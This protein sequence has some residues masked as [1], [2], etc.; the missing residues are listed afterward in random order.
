MLVSILAL[1]FQVEAAEEASASEEASP[2]R[3]LT[4]DALPLASPARLLTDDAFPVGVVVSGHGAAPGVYVRFDESDIA[5]FKHDLSWILSWSGCAW[6]LQE[7][8]VYGDLTCG[9]D[10]LAV[11]AL[12]ASRGYNGTGLCDRADAELCAYRTFLALCPASCLENVGTPSPRNKS[13]VVICLQDDDAAVEEYLALMGERVGPC[14]SEQVLARCESDLVARALCKLT[15][16]HPDAFDG[17]ATGPATAIPVAAWEDEHGLL[18]RRLRRI[19]S[20]RAAA[21]AAAARTLQAVPELLYRTRFVLMPPSGDMG[22]VAAGCPTQECTQYDSCAGC[23]HDDLGALGLYGNGPTC[24]LDV[25]GTYYMGMKNICVSNNMYM[26]CY[27]SP[28]QI[29]A[30]SA[31]RRAKSAIESETICEAK[32]FARSPLRV[33][34][35]VCD[36]RVS[37]ETHSG[38]FCPWRNVDIS[39]SRLVPYRCEDGES[40]ALCIPRED[41]EKLCTELGADCV[42]IDF[43]RGEDRCFLNRAGSCPLDPVA[44]LTPSGFTPPELRVELSGPG[45]PGDRFPDGHVARQLKHDEA[46]TSTGHLLLRKSTPTTRHAPKFVTKS[47]YICVRLN[48]AL[49]GTASEDSLCSSNPKNV[50]EEAGLMFDAYK[51]DANEAVCLEREGC[52]ALCASL[53]TCVGFD[54]HKTLGICYLNT[55]DCKSSLYHSA[56]TLFDLVEKRPPGGCEISVSGAP[57][58]YGFGGAYEETVEGKTYTRGEDTLEYSA[59]SG[60]SLRRGP[61]V[62]YTTCSAP[63]TCATQG[64]LYFYCPGSDLVSVAGDEYE[65]CPLYNYC[66]LNAERGANE[67]AL[68]YNGSSSLNPLCDAKQ[69]AAYGTRAF[70]TPSRA[71]LIYRHPEDEFHDAAALLAKDLF[72]DTINSPHVRTVQLAGADAY[73]LRVVD[74]AAAEAELGWTLGPPAGT[75]KWVSDFLFLERYLDGSFLNGTATAGVP[76]P[77]VGGFLDSADADDSQIELWLPE[78]PEDLDLSFVKVVLLSRTGTTDSYSEPP[79]DLFPL[80]RTA[81]GWYRLTLA[82]SPFVQFDCALG[83]ALAL[84]EDECSLGTHDCD[85]HAVCT[86]TPFGHTCT[87]IDGWIGDGSLCL[88]NRWYGKDAPLSVV[89]ENEAEIHAGWHVKEIELFADAACTDPIETSLQWHEH[90][91]KYCRGNNVLPVLP[92]NSAISQS[93]VTNANCQG[94]P[95]DPNYEPVDSAASTHAL[96]P[97]SIATCRSWCLALP[98]CVGFDYHKTRDRCYI[99]YDSTSEPCKD[100]V[101]TGTLGDDPDYS[102]YSKE[103]LVSVE[104]SGAYEK[105]P[106]EL[107]ADGENRSEWWSAALHVKPRAASV[108]VGVRANR[109]VMSARVTQDA[110]H[111]G[112]A[113]H[114]AAAYRVHVSLAPTLGLWKVR[115]GTSPTARHVQ[116]LVDT[117][118]DRRYTVTKLVSGQPP[119]VDLTCG[120]AGRALPLSTKVLLKFDF[121]PTPCHCKELCLVWAAKGCASWTMYVERDSTSRDYSHI[122]SECYL[123]Q[124]AY[125]HK[126]TRKTPNWVSGGIDVLLFGFEPT[127]MSPGELKSLKIHAAGLSVKNPERQRLKIVPETSSCDAP[128]SPL[129]DG[130]RCSA[131]GVCTPG[132]ASFSTTHA[133]WPIRIAGGSAAGTYT[134]CYCQ[135]S[136]AL[137]EEWSAVP[138]VLTVRGGFSFSVQSKTEAADGQ[139]ATFS[140]LL[141]ASATPPGTVNVDWDPIIQYAIVQGQ[142]CSSGSVS[143]SGEQTA[144]PE[145]VPVLSDYVVTF[146]GVSLAASTGAYTVCARWKSTSDYL[147]AASGQDNR[148]LMVLSPPTLPVGLRGVSAWSGAAGSDIAV[149]LDGVA[150]ITVAEMKVAKAADSACE[151]PNLALSVGKASVEEEALVFTVNLGVGRYTVCFC[152]PTCAT[153]GILHVT[154]RANLDL[155]YVLPPEGGSIEVTGRSLSTKDGIVVIPCGGTCGVTAGMPLSPIPFSDVPWSDFVELTERYCVASALPL[156]VKSYADLQRCSSKCTSCTGDGCYCDGFFD[157]DVDAETLCMP[158]FECEATCAAMDDCYGINMN[159]QRDR[160][161]LLSS[162]CA[163]QVASPAMLGA[164]WSFSLLLKR[165]DPVRRLAANTTDARRLTLPLDIGSHSTRLR[166]PYVPPTAGRYKVCFCDSTLGPCTSATDFGVSLGIAHVS[167]VECVVGDPHL[168]EGSCVKQVHGGHRCDGSD[169]PAVHDG[170]IESYVLD[171]AD[172]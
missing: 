71:E 81:D 116:F 89:V 106:A 123:L 152:A 22:L 87:C 171:V 13:G 80:T 96:C 148:D 100:Q 63:G 164:S 159:S 76:P 45:L 53:D 38:A 48:L 9:D 99:N 79:P 151:V 7:G 46:M 168:G 27:A 153:A 86:N 92:L 93:D 39:D 158:R 110:A 103:V 30:R 2:A 74:P 29:A 10:E 65:P 111:E 125:H 70:A 11:Q 170:F 26:K 32:F 146:N 144:A 73:I 57:D 95:T 140:L 135:G 84:D 117:M 82:S 40:N 115:R 64:Q 21:F 69:L 131:A 161:T 42:S 54:M 58:E 124:E 127:I 132:P 6:E 105:H 91:N 49:N 47:G 133:T 33:E 4:D 66:V 138:G 34:A 120:D 23:T 55:A 83:L 137:A 149:K 17:L 162:S 35:R 25:A 3:V 20:T 62:Y 16:G 97:G 156:P 122:H 67:L 114:A 68:M 154:A 141:R 77:A 85:E 14:S 160:C 8:F 56:S 98:E 121:V 18:S 109:G 12:Y 51:M 90:P 136:C 118:E 126:L 1:L 107:V 61:Y 166:F 52:E 128:L 150:S 102:Y 5:F 142:D 43:L 75:A 134:V 19:S 101:L 28:A 155:D 72:R 113:T 130:V 31:E 169:V 88:P 165:I 129:V 147:V 24:F 139:S 15:C 60:I 78:L 41:C 157:E 44:A 37:Y 108:T 172:P 163:E 94:K 119:C 167:G 59:T 36:S 112:V 50:S 104:S 143:S 145:T